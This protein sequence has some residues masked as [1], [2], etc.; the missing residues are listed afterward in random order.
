MFL[1]SPE[2]L[3]CFTYSLG[4]LHTLR[5][6]PDNLSQICSPP[7]SLIA[8][9]I[10]QGIFTRFTFSLITFPKFSA[11]TTIFV[12]RYYCRTQIQFMPAGLWWYWRYPISLCFCRV[13]PNYQIC[14]P[15][16]FNGWWRQARKKRLERYVFLRYFNLHRLHHGFRLRRTIIF[17]CMADWL[18]HSVSNLARSTRLGSNPVVGT[19][20]HKPSANS[21]VHPSEPS[22]WVLI[23]NSPKYFCLIAK[24]V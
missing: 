22:K 2:F 1:Q 7:N 21:S 16:I 3:D 17:N 12:V 19:A 8:L 23:G 15:V 5:L 11:G 10:H 24:T 13:T 20:K 18:R 4:N 14:D 9:R 6:L